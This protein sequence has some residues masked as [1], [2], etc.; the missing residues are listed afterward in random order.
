MRLL[1]IV[2]CVLLASCVQNIVQ[3]AAIVQKSFQVKEANYTVR[4]EYPIISGASD[5]LNNQLA[6]AALTHLEQ[7][8]DDPIPFKDYAR[9][10]GVD[11]AGQQWANE[12][13]LTIAHQTP[14]TV[15]TLC[16][17]YT[18]TG[19]AHPSVYH[20]YEVYD[21]SSGRRLELNDLLEDG[22]L[23]AIRAIANVKGDFPNEPEIGLLKD[24]LVFRPDPDARTVPDTKIEYAKLK[25]ILKPQFFP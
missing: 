10:F 14:A 4:L 11:A 20:H 18:N 9:N 6:L 1:Y 5:A 15:T 7:V 16:K 12:A 21:A 25:G 23:D 17:T 24:A 3:Q 2:L 8:E 19:A 22:K 13:I